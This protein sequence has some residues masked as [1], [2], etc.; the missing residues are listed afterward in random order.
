MLYSTEDGVNRIL[1]P[2]LSPHGSVLFYLPSH[3]MLRGTSTSRM[4]TNL[5]P[6]MV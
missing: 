2:V 4:G 1:D 3:A 5:P 6:L